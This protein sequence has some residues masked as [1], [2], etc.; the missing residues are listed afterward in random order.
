M[1]AM[2]DRFAGCSGPQPG[3][4][5]R[6]Y[7]FRERHIYEI[8]PGSNC[9][10][11][12]D[13]LK[14]TRPPQTPEFLEVDDLDDAIRAE[15][16]IEYWGGH[17]GTTGQAFRINDGVWIS[18]PQPEGMSTEPEAYYRTVL[19][20][21]APVPLE[22]IRKG[23]NKVQFKAGSQLQRLNFC[24]GFYWVYSFTLII[25][26]NSIKAHPEGFIKEPSKELS[27]ERTIGDLPFFEAEITCATKP[28]SRVDFIGH[29]E[30]FDWKGTGRYLDWHY[31]YRYG[32]LAAHIGTTTKKPY[33]VRWNNF[34]VPDQD[35]PVRVAARITDCSGISFMTH[36]ISVLLKREERTVIMYKA[37]KVPE[38]FGS[39]IGQRKS[40]KINVSEDPESAR[41]ACLI[42]SNWSAAHGEE[43]TFNGTVIADRVG[44][45]HDVSC[46]SI[47]IPLRLIL[48]GTNEFSIFSTTDEH[49]A[50][51]NWPGPV[52]LM[53]YARK[54][55]KA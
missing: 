55:A 2:T 39:R 14:L 1:T 37:W 11:G 3:D 36:E 31:R 8:D 16:V 27:A 12:S 28:V 44:V 23:L 38:N 54:A 50:E 29:Y 40:C 49:A 43:I 52:L 48:K 6:E 32:D 47:P 33:I 18:V 25:Y 26:Y 41:A 9:I 24:F 15:M 7:T 5:F 53:E 30:D 21:V 22:Q 4:I 51:V 35:G 42:F 17:I 34:W 19:G 10:P 13:G 46:D 20:A 45:V